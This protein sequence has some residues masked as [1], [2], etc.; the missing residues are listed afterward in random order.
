ML[1]T[2]LLESTDSDSDNLPFRFRLE[3]TVHAAQAEHSEQIK[4]SYAIRSASD[5]PET[6]D[7]EGPAQF[8]HVIPRQARELTQR[9]DAQL[10]ADRCQHGPGNACRQK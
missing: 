7:A 8:E 2:S 4:Y 6:V 1:D 3:R 9:V 5:V 10:A